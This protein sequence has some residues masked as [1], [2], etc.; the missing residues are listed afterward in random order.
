VMVG[1]LDQATP[2]ALAR[3]LASRL[4]FAQFLELEDC[5]HC[6]QIER[7]QAFVEAVNGFLPQ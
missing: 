6:P 2:P 4:P 1:A 7:P 3:E 5:G